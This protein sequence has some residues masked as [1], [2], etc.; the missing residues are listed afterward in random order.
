MAAFHTIKKEI[1]KQV[2]LNNSVRV[3]QWFTEIW[4]IVTLSSR[5]RKRGIKVFFTEM[6]GKYAMWREAFTDDP[7]SIVGKVKGKV[8]ESW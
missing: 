2:D 8:L 7:A 6:N 4:E 1:E 3:T 5:L